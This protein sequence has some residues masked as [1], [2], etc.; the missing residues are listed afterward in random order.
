M[1][2]R[3][4]AKTVQGTTLFISSGLAASDGPTPAAMGAPLTLDDWGTL[5]QTLA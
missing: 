4:I 3:S 1:K 2:S 5:L